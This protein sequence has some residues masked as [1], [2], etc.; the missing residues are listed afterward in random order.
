MK[1][2]LQIG[3]DATS[4][5]VTVDGQPYGEPIRIMG[6]VEAE[7]FDYQAEADKTNSP[8][9]NP[10]N[11][12]FQNF[13]NNVD[14]FVQLAGVLNIY[15][16]LLFRGKTPAELDMPQPEENESL[17]AYGG[18]IPAN[19]IDL[20]HGI[21]GAMTEVG[22]LAEVLLD[23]LDG[24]APDRVNVVEEVGDQRWYLNRCLRWAG[25]TDEQCERINVDKLHGRHGSAFDIFRDANR[26]LDAERVGLERAVVEPGPL[27]EAAEQPQRR[28]MQQDG[29]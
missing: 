26:D 8:V 29:E 7:G 22:E 6:R 27:V 24:K 11:V 16:K 17:A 18:A 28:F 5:R 15:K 23:M 3:F 13:R 21:L 19:E 20:V 10:Q 25:V 14:T 9:W 4:R 2:E 12:I 1:V